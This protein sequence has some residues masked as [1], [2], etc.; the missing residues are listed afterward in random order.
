[1]GK[2]LVGR[3]S[4][5]SMYLLMSVTASRVLR[6]LMNPN[7]VSRTLG[8][9]AVCNLVARILANTLYKASRRLIG[10]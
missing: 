2:A 4:T 3:S 5:S 8:E 1:M 7:W 9:S 6:L 10:L